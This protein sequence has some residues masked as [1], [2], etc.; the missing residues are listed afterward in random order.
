[1]PDTIV[2]IFKGEIISVWIDDEWFY[3]STPYCTVNIPLEETESIIKE[4][5]ALA[6]AWKAHESRN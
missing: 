2:D 5:Q 3:L 1:M 4:L 6:V